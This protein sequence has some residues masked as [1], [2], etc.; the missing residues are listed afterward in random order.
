MS[1]VAVWLLVKSRAKSQFSAPVW[2]WF[3]VSDSLWHQN[4]HHLL[5]M[6]K[7]S[8]VKDEKLRPT[9]SQRRLPKMSRHLQ[10]KPRCQNVTSME[11]WYSPIFQI[12][13]RLW[14][15]K[16][17]SK[18]EALEERTF[19]RFIQAS[20]V[21]TQT[22]FIL[23][24][25]QSIKASTSPTGSPPGIWIFG[26]FL[27][28]CLPPGAEKL[29]KCPHPQENY[30]I[31]VLTCHKILGIHVLHINIVDQLTITSRVVP[32]I[33]FTNWIHHRFYIVLCNNT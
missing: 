6:W 33:I 29:F 16:K 7:K 4:E 11:S 20:Q 28:K 32:K 26:K 18:L 15:Q 17:F 31:T 9:K 22:Y 21:S 5:C 2:S 13:S 8:R 1:A 27:F 19:D 3:L 23:I 25:Y 24:M 10:Q 30:Q 12:S 14:H